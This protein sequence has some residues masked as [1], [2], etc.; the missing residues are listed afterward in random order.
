M[1][2]PVHR[3][4]SGGRPWFLYSQPKTDPSIKRGPYQRLEDKEVIR[5]ERKPL[6]LDTFP[7]DD[8]SWADDPEAISQHLTN[9]W[10]SETPKTLA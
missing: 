4:I 10:R 5:V 9:E 3:Q 2:M 1:V 6:K 7:Y 8:E